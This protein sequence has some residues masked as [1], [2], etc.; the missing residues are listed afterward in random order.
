MKSLFF[1][2]IFL[3]NVMMPAQTN[4]SEINSEISSGNFDKAKELI[5]QKIAA[6]KLSGQE[7]Y[8]LNFQID[9]ME[10]IKRDFRRDEDYVKDQLKKYYPEL[11]DG[12]ITEWEED[13]SLEMKIINGEKK[14]FNNSVPN[15]FRVNKNAKKTKEN[16]EGTYHSK[17]NQFLSTHLPES[18]DQFE[19]TKNNIDNP[20]RMKLHYTLSVDAD[21]VP[22]GE[23]I[24]C[25]L[26]YPKENIERQTDV[27]LISVNDDE[28]IIADDSNPQ[29]TIYLEKISEKGKPTIFEMELEYTANS[30]YYDIDPEKI[31]PY[32]KDSEYYKEY[33]SERAP[34]IIFTDEMKKLSNEIIGDTKNPYEKVVKIFSWISSSIPWASAREYSTLENISGYCINNMHGDCGIKALTF[35]TLARLNGVPARWQSGWM[36]HP[37]SVNLHDWA[38]YYLEGYGWIPVDVDYGIQHSENPKVKYYYSSGIDSYRLIVN[39]DYSNPLF[40][41]KIYPRSETVDFQRGEVEWRGGNLYFDKWDYNMKVEYLDEAGT[42]SL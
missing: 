25:W 19:K 27:K 11:T 42:G 10:R 6:G 9:L 14:Y 34:H 18:I 22:E 7:V 17:L 37:G 12:M 26:P 24:R 38:E 3:V 30:A 21:A 16:I 23:I 29:R 39:T 35:I 40:P 1:S 32:E 31:K 28:Y 2:L 15:L 5:L 33:T 4:F 41:A 13:G 36:L 8:D 20:R